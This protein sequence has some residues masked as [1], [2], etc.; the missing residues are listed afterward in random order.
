[1]ADPLPLGSTNLAAPAAPQGGASPFGAF[2][3][4]AAAFPSQPAAPEVPTDLTGAPIS[5]EP[6]APPTYRKTRTRR[7]SLKIVPADIA[8]RV[9]EFFDHDMQDR[10][11]E[12]DLRLQRY[13]KLR[14]WV[15]GKDWPW[16]DSSDIPLPDI[17]EKCLRIED[18]LHNAVMSRRPA[19]SAK[20]MAEKSDA[21][22][23]R[24]IDALID[25]Q[26]F[27]EGRGESLVGDLASQFVEDGVM[28]AFI[29]WVREKRELSD[30][31]IFDPIPGGDPVPYFE[32]LIRQTFPGSSATPAGV[33]GWQW[34]VIDADSDETFTVDFYSKDD[35]RIE[36]VTAR[37]VIVHDGPVPMAKE[38]DEI[39]HPGRAA[40][41]QMPGP[42]NPDGATHVI[43]IDYPT[44]GEIRRLY[45]TGYYDCPGLSP[46]EAKAALAALD[47]VSP[48][49]SVDADEFR[50]QKD[51]LQGIDSSRQ[52]DLPA[53][54]RTLTRL[55]CFDAYDIDD[56]GLDEDV[57]WWMILDTSLL[58]KAKPLSEMYPA[59]PPRRPFAEAS[60]IPVR[61]RRSGIGI[62]ELVEGLH[63]AIKA[64]VDQ[65]VDSG[66]L[67]NSPFFFYRASGGMKPEVINLS[68]G[69]GY[70]LGDAQNDVNF[71]QIGNPN[72]AAAQQN[73][74]AYLESKE[75]RLTMVGDIQ[76]GRVPAGRSSALRTVGGMSQLQGQGE[77]RPE[78][79][80]RRFFM[81][82]TEIYAQVHELNQR[83]LPANKKFRVAGVMGPGEDPYQEISQ[84]SE[85]SGRFQFDFS[86]NI[87][88]TSKTQLQE[89]LGTLLQTYVGPLAI[90]AGIVKPDGIYRLMR[91]YGRAFGIEPD[92]YLVAP[93]P[94][95][96]QPAS[97]AQDV[98][99]AILNNETPAFSRP[100]EIGGWAEHLQKI[101]GFVQSDK[102]GFLSPL[103]TDMLGQYIQQATQAQQAEQQQLMMAAQ[104]Q[105]Q[106]GNQGQPGPGAPP[107]GPPP[108]ANAPVHNQP[109]KVN[110]MTMPAQAGGG[111]SPP[112]AGA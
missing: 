108:D 97:S 31:R 67:S 57:I 56:D 90:Q 5:L 84:R 32:G 59:N 11:T 58:L 12:R 88:N 1:M 28:T 100:A 34:S 25:Y 80:L 33:D 9:K 68:P 37:E 107:Q 45:K 19:V 13:A 53:S 47:T 21:Q 89:S 39:L 41:L 60:F 94:G 51:A 10:S 112:R 61:G 106:M 92:Q 35:G 63:D 74:V 99:W 44:V 55:M 64:M 8:K 3:P 65:G 43:M 52:S 22:K 42:S 81:G 16:P 98:L 109:G 77:A 20:P 93:S 49:S 102:L 30:V 29:P 110:D 48:I 82:L 54:H 26:L 91:D 103:Q 87:L 78:R 101:D 96:D 83:F 69:E 75:E 15:E 6:Q 27:V 38:W 95:A 2:A 72:A 105:Q 70:P 66:T 18:T 50:A 76:L 36:F 71:P 111:G 7:D 40:N 104:Q 4:G 79:I 23:A 14:M 73:M 86:A 24:K 62:P 17:L 46:A 85:I